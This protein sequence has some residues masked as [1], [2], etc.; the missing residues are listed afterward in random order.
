M[1]LKGYGP[2]YHSFEM[3]KIKL[4]YGVKDIDHSCRLPKKN[5]ERI[6]K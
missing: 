3:L 6:F 1:T 2:N 5:K 4:K